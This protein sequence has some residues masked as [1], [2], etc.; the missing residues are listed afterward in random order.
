M[1]I[2]SWE[3]SIRANLVLALGRIEVSWQFLGPVSQNS[4]SGRNYN[5]TPI[6]VMPDHVTRMFM[7]LEHLQFVNMI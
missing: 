1:V 2:L 3:N 5:W 7:K 6:I 4:T